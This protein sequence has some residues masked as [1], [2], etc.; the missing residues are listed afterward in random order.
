M[1]LAYFSYIYDKRH[2][3][4][5]TPEILMSRRT[6]YNATQEQKLYIIRVFLLVLSLSM[7]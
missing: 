4:T 6:S 2:N 1:N 7:A 3:N 5:Q